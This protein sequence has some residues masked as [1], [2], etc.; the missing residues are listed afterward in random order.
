MATTVHKTQWSERQQKTVYGCTEK[1]LDKMIYSEHRQVFG[2]LRMLAMSILSDAQE[3]L[4]MGDAEASR[5]YMNCA[6]YVI[7]KLEEPK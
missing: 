7:E 6:K 4:H 3:V 5:Q 2:G 1:E